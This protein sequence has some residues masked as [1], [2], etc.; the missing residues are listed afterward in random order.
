MGNKAVVVGATG[1]VGKEV[2]EQL[3]EDRSYDRV[4]V[5][6]RNK[7]ENNHEKL[8]QHVIDFDNMDRISE[9]LAGSTV[10]CT[11]DEWKWRNY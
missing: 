4:I 2:V 7:L 8:E 3:L 1:L 10:F 6:V 11:Q 9:L 5:L